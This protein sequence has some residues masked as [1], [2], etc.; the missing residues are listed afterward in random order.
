[1]SISPSRYVFGSVSWYGLLIVTGAALA[2][3]LASREEKR[4]GL[5]K[6][7]IIDLAL[8][9]LPMG[10]IG[11]RLYY[12]AFSWPQ[13]RDN[14]ISI[15]HI[16]EGGLAIYGGLIAGLLTVILFC[17]HRRLS[18]LK[19][20]DVIAPGVALAQALGRWGNYFNQEAYGLPLTNPALFFFPI[21]VQIMENG[22]PVWHMATFFYESL[23]DFAIFL[24]LIIARR[25]L[26]HKTGDVFFAY[27][28]LYGAARLVVENFR[29]DSLYSGG[30][31][32][33][34]QLLSVL[35]CGAIL[36]ALYIRVN[37][38]K[39]NAACGSA[40]SQNPNS[41]FNGEAESCSGKA[42]GPVPKALF[43]LALP[44]LLSLIL[45]CFGVS[46]IPLP[47][48]GSQFLYLGLS[49]LYLILTLLVLFI[50]SV[51]RDCPHKVEIN[52]ESAADSSS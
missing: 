18:F 27:L 8:W 15:L 46:P 23:L 21:G 47:T 29:M 38:E 6:D 44:I 24:F 7:T 14:P 22:V 5:P 51:N 30:G 12:V 48:A 33:I 3:F 40:V 16:H 17:R 41:T 11:A 20:C 36:I 25:K 39:K 35:I 32:R 1:M 26:P 19:V 2:V 49:S 52:P 31:V 13:Y 28:F 43:I 34:S 50:S 10:I 45:F 9:T 37:K 4:A 42:P